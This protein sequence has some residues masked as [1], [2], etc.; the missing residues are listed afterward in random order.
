MLKLNLKKG[1]NTIS[2]DLIGRSLVPQVRRNQ[3]IEII[4]INVGCLGACTYCKTK[5]ARGHLG[6]YP[7]HSLA[8][9]L[10]SVIATGAKE[11]WL[12]SED[13]GAYGES[14]DAC[15]TVDLGRDIGTDLSDAPA[16]LGGGVAC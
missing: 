3:F 11:V 8:E 6:S 1:K 2:S 14:N 12:S 10:R 9:R 7:V 16:C 13:T 5:H 4:P 15:R